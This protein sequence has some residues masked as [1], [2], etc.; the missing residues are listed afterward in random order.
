VIATQF[1]RHVL[2]D[3]D[4]TA[5]R[6]ALS[7]NRRSADAPA[8]IGWSGAV[9]HENDTARHSAVLR[10]WEE[11]FGARL[12]AVG[13]ATLHLSVAA[14]PVDPEHALHVAAEHF[15]FCPDNVWQG[16][17]S[18]TRYAD[19]LVDRTSWSFWRD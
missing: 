1:A 6:L 2:E 16:A 15:A 8:D 12:V 11:R 17:G 14:P 10:S 3:P 13:T 5:P 4:L 7:P 19:T 9:N 18:L